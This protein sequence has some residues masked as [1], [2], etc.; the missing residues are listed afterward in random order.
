MISLSVFSVALTIVAVATTPTTVP[1]D[2]Q[3]EWGKHGRCDIAADRLTITVGSAGWG[4]GP[5]RAVEFDAE[6]QSLHW[7][8]EGV[9]DNF[10][11]GKSKNVIVHNTQ[12]FG[13][14]GEQGYARC[15]K[16][17]HR[18][19]WPPRQKDAPRPEIAAVKLYEEV[20]RLNAACVNAGGGVSGSPDCDAGTF[21]EAELEK[22]GYCIDYPNKEKLAKCEDVQWRR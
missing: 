6:L 8:E 13:M 4:Q 10:V 14:S 5:L 2:M 9:V 21:K 7:K 12:G 22:L 20:K 3:G 1:I 15:G 11:R 17:L 18:V 19:S 16:G